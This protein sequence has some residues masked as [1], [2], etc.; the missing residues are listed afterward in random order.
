MECLFM[1]P[2]LNATYLEDKLGVSHGQAVR[3]LNTLEEKHILH[4]DDRK[5][6]RMFYFTELIDL[7]K[8]F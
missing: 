4:G 8:G 7:A 2:V 1:H 3:Y 6:G 5:R